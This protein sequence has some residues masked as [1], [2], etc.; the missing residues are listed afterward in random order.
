MMSIVS[1]NSAQVNL[2]IVKLAV[3]SI[4]FR[5]S[6]CSFWSYNNCY[7]TQRKAK[8]IEQYK[9]HIPDRYQNRST[10]LLIDMEGKHD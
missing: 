3:V 9:S 6:V 1:A 5:V 8:F 7:R 2:P 4:A 10:V